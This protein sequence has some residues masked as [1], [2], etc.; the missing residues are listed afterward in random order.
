[1]QVGSGHALTFIQS[2]ILFGRRRA[3]STSIKRMICGDVA[4]VFRDKMVHSNL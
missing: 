1:M 3:V 4:V 2:M